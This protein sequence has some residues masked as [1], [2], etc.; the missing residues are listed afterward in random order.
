MSTKTKTRHGMT[1]PA[2]VEVLGPIEDGYGEILSPDALGFLAELERRFGA[3][4]RDL[5]ARRRAGRARLEAGALPDFLAETR[6]IREADW[7]SRRCRPTCW[8]AASRSPGPVDRKM[9]INALNSGAPRVHGRLR[10]RDHADLGQP[11][12]GPGQP[13]RRGPPARIDFDRSRTAASATRSTSGPRRSS[14]ARAAGTSREARA[15]RRRADVRRAV[16]LR[17]VLLPQRQGAARAR[18]R[19]RT[20][21]CR[22]WRATSRRGCG[23]TC[24]LFAQERARHAAAARSRRRC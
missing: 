16:R 22:R 18:H 12:R 5:L 1:T 17:P 24:S 9:I 14:C 11:G 10:G 6:E 2:G 21:T 19:A 4:R 8:T 3:A 13:A 15:G 7:R 20:S 23:T